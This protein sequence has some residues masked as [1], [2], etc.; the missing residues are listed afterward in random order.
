[1]SLELNPTNNGRESS[2]Y[3]KDGKTIDISDDPLIML[4]IQNMKQ[5]VVFDSIESVFNTRVFIF[6]LLVHLMNPLLFWCTNWRAQRLLFTG[7]Y[8]D[9]LYNGTS[10]IATILSIIFYIASNRVHFVVHGA[11]EVPLLLYSFHKVMIAFRYATLSDIEYNR[12]MRSSGDLSRTYVSQTELISGWLFNEPG[13][14]EF[15]VLAASMQVGVN[16]AQLRF[17]VPEPT[18]SDD[19]TINFQ[20]W[21]QLLKASTKDNDVQCNETI[22]DGLT[23]NRDGSYNVCAYRLSLGIIAAADNRVRIRANDFLWK[24]TAIVTII[25]AMIPF[26]VNYDQLTMHI[27]AADILFFICSTYLNIMYYPLLQVFLMACWVDVLR[28][29]EISAVVADLMRVKDYAVEQPLLDEVRWNRLM[30]TAISSTAIHRNSVSASTAVLQENDVP[31][32]LTGNPDIDFSES[33][34]L[35]HHID[36]PMLP[37]DTNISSISSGVATDEDPLVVSMQQLIRR[38]SMHK[39]NN[40][41]NIN[42]QSSPLQASPSLANKNFDDVDIPRL[43]VTYCHN[44]TNWVYLRCILQQFGDRIRVRINYFVGEYY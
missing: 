13:V 25:N 31:I 14:S 26:L 21:L 33:S 28:Q 11:I 41:N 24:F 30:K 40:S 27:T 19:A 38:S 3:A 34:C 16:V 17:T 42:S 37:S 8:L 36:N 5:P 6:Q 44:I 12:I 18:T 43:E 20:R 7:G 15:F 39:L 2:L 29:Q 22:V 35:S 1:M 9:R 10:S 4:G 32:K 23:R